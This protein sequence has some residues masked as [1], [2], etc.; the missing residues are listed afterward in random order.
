MED[1]LWLALCGLGS[2]T[3]R[4][5][6]EYWSKGGADGS[7]GASIG[8]DFAGPAKV[9]LIVLGLGEGSRDGLA[10]VCEEMDG[11]RPRPDRLP[12]GVSLFKSIF[13]TDSLLLW[14]V[15]AKLLRLLRITGDGAI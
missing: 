9:E 4:V 14:P 7:F 13:S 8:R 12:C 6:G 3:E 1:L 5:K 2:L 11:E 15:V 10:G